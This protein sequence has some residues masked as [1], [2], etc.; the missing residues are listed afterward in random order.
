MAER[1]LAKAISERLNG[2]SRKERIAKVRKLASGSPEDDTFVRETF[3][4]LYKEAFLSPHR[5]ADGRSGAGQRRARS[6][7]RR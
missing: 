5:A 1:H 4:D 6:A 7:G 3:P 2:L